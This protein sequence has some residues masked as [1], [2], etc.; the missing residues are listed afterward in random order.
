MLDHSTVSRVPPAGPA[1]P[2]RRRRAR[3]VGAV[4]VLGATLTGCVGGATGVHQPGLLLAAAAVVLIGV[5]T[6]G[7]ILAVGFIG[8]ITMLA[9][10]GR[11]RARSVEDV[12]LLMTG[13]TGAYGTV[14]ARFTA[15]VHGDRPRQPD[16]AEPE[17]C[18][19]PSTRR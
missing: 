19:P 16:D 7:V 10:E 5:V 1:R 8:A 13:I 2:T 6:V 14:F 4:G 18:P 11:R 9:T 15:L 3:R 12:R 17:P